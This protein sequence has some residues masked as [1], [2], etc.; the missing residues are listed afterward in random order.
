MAWP[1]NKRGADPWRSAGRFV[2]ASLA[3]LRKYP[4]RPPPF[5]NRWAAD[6]GRMVRAALPW[7][8]ACW[9]GGPVAAG[10]WPVLGVPGVG[11]WGRG[12]GR[13]CGWSGVGLGLANGGGT[14]LPWRLWLPG[15][16]AVVGL[17]RLRRPRL[18]LAPRLSLRLPAVAAVPSC[19]WSPRL[20]GPAALAAAPRRRRCGRLLHRPGPGPGGI[21]VRRL[22][23]GHSKKPTPSRGWAREQSDVDAAGPSGQRQGLRD[24]SRRARSGGPDC[25]GR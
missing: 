5:V 6:R 4:L 21:A 1:D 9:C 22:P 19:C 11:F 24:G 14:L 10:L 12:G 3:R 16:P 8:V 23:W 20:W 2:S 7:G 17:Q 18:S 15:A 25:R 13:R